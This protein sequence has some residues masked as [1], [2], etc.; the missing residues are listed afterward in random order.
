MTVGGD[1]QNDTSTLPIISQSRLTRLRKAAVRAEHEQFHIFVHKL[2]QGGICVGTVH[3]S[4]LIFFIIACLES[5]THCHSKDSNTTGAK[6]T[7]HKWSIP[8]LD[9]RGKRT[10]FT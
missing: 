6:Q 9:G 1:S 3:D 2:L 8:T 7:R 5:T 4:A 10:R